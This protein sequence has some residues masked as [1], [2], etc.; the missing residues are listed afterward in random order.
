MRKIFIISLISLVLAA[1]I[2]FAFAGKLGD[3]ADNGRAV[4]NI[5]SST[6]KI[7]SDAFLNNG[8]M[9]AKFTAD[10][11]KIN[12]QLSIEGVP[13]AAK[14][15]VLVVDDPDAPSGTFTHWTV[16]NI[17]PAVAGIAENSVPEG[18]VQ[19]V[20]SDGEPGYVP[21]AP[22]SGTHRYYFKVYALDTKLD[23]RGSAGI[24]DLLSV[25]EGHILDKAE[26]MGFYGRR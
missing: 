7:S 23:L 25:M 16:W 14:S 15:L 18:A 5:S 4:N 26:L 20:T 21:P 19:G 3:N 11:E 24:S 13:Q 1:V 6:M 17:D 8:L 9:P 10:G 22:P 12:P 2:F